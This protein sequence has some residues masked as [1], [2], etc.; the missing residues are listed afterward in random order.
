MKKHLA[1]FKPFVKTS[2]AQSEFSIRALILGILLSLLFAVGNA[3]LGLK[4]G[5]TISASIPAAVL[6]MAILR[7][8]FRKSGDFR[9]QHRTNSCL[10]LEK[11]L[12]EG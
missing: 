9:K 10:R 6:S 2:D 5:I 1:T 12:Q 7:A 4:V 8:F 11:A 3:Y